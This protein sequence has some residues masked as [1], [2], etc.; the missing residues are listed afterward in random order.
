MPPEKLSVSVKSTLYS[1]YL[2]A[3]DGSILWPGHCFGL[4]H[5]PLA[6]CGLLFILEHLLELWFA[7]TWHFSPATPPIYNLLCLFFCLFLLLFENLPHLSI[8]ILSAP[9]HKDINDKRSLLPSTQSGG[10]DQSPGCIAHYC[11][12]QN[13]NFSSRKTHEW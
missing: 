9:F 13:L 3:C 12:T 5:S 10:I 4:V 1:F 11:G 6:Y 7:C 2:L 8:E